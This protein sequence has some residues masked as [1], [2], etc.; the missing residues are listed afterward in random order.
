MVTSY[1]V[2]S[3]YG[4]LDILI[5]QKENQ[6]S[7]TVNQLEAILQ[8]YPAAPKFAK[9]EEILQYLVEIGYFKEID[10]VLFFDF[11]NTCGSL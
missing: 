11:K 2:W 7:L 3:V 10:E 8:D 4:M 5:R 9:K 6:D 1:I